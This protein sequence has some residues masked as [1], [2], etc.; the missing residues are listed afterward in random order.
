V[1]VLGLFTSVAV[2]SSS[3][4]LF[5]WYLYS[6][7]VLSGIGIDDVCLSFDYAEL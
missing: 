4:S 7:F 1:I 3:P 6:V 2:V 5:Q